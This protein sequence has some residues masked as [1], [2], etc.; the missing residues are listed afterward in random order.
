MFTVKSYTE[1]LSE[2][3]SLDEALKNVRLSNIEV[4]RV[5]E[6]ITFNFIC[7]KVVDENLQHAI[8][9]KAEKISSSVFSVVNVSVKKISNDVELIRNAIFKY[10]T[11]SYPS[12]SIF[13]KINDVVVKSDDN[14]VKYK[15]IL[16]K[17]G[18][19]YVNKNGIIKKI[20]ENLSHK[21]CADFS[22]TTDV[23]DDVETVDLLSEEVFESEIQ[24]VE[25]RTIKV[26]DVIPIDDIYVEDTAVYIEDAISPGSV[27]IC[28]I[29]TE[30]VERKTKNDKPFYIIHL[31]DTT[32]RTSGIYFT[33][34]NTLHKIKELKA[35]DAIIARCRIELKE[36]KK[37]SLV[38]EK[39]NRCTFPSEFVK[40]E[41]LKKQPPKEYR[42]IFPSPANTVRVSSVFDNSGELPEELTSK[43]YVVFDLETTGLEPMNNGITE[44]GAVKIIDGK[45][46]EQFTTLV[47]PDYHISA[48]NESIT[49]ISEEM[50]K[51]SPRIGA[52]LPDFM[53]F[54][55][56]C[57]LV[58][59]NSDFD[60]KFI[61]RFASIEEYE[62]TNPVMDTMVM[63]R[64]YVPQMRKADLQTVA[65]Y[66][67]I[68]FHHHRALSDS[69][70][71]AEA[72]IE[73]MKIK[74]QKENQ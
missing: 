19:D 44:I 14:L 2:I 16:T 64:Q 68:V 22:G 25:H 60:L 56:G 53:K 42:V 69:Y 66:F 18:I 50:V 1:F 41:K 58:A 24:R 61:R 31:D 8:L 17:D 52:V 55:E 54:I 39:I 4:D 29:I 5:K 72:F 27:V 12:I 37:R 73:L 20:N 30:I 63:F 21:F 10:L 74:K 9:G 33:R 15:L 57:T 40:K 23:K 28:G 65:D 13:L 35:G 62:V 43:N 7:D 59:H 48:E 34:K 47:K 3:R 26:N 36:D 71:T 6:S 38:Y 70:A 51:D 67:N 46:A 49:G 45:I 32:S 11:E